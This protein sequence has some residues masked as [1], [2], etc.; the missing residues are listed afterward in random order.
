MLCSNPLIGRMSNEAVPAAANFG[1]LVPNADFSGGELVA[2][3]VGAQCR[4]D[5]ILD[6]GPAPS[7]FTA[8]VLPGNNYHVYDYPL[9]WANLRADVERRAS[10][11]GVP[12][13]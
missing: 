9:Y 3:G 11:F 10:A 6:I 8:F 4:G 2:K 5:G 13:P 1:S 12:A 7:G